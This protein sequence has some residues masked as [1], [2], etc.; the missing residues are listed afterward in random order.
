M[1]TK[2]RRG[3]AMVIGVMLA[4]P[5]AGAEI[6]NPG[7]ESGRDPGSIARLEA[8]SPAISGWRI[9]GTAVHYARTGWGAAEGSRSVGLHTGDTERH[10]GIAQKLSTTPGVEYVLTF[11]YAPAP[12]AGTCAPRELTIRAA[13][14]STAV[15]VKGKGSAAAP[16]W[17]SGSWR[18]TAV[19]PFTTLEFAN[20]QGAHAC[21]VLVDRLGLEA[22]ESDR[23]GAWGAVRSIYR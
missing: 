13:G 17:R 12:F 19:E 21:G 7:F 1:D 18:F 20:E 16:G 5:A 15:T 4:G 8:R 11:S 14:Q 2:R 9:T 23:R 3:L 22:F 6:E 10:S